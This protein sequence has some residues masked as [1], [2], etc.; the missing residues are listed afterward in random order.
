M[1]S[2][3]GLRFLCFYY[4]SYLIDAERKVGGRWEGSLFDGLN[5]LLCRQYNPARTLSR[6]TIEASYSPSVCRKWDSFI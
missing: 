5:V 2:V 4:E 6:H 3:H 1:S